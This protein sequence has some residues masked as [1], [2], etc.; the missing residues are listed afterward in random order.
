MAYYKRYRKKPI[1]K[2][3]K[4][5]KEKYLSMSLAQLEVEEKKLSE[6]SGRLVYETRSE[7]YDEANSS[8]GIDGSEYNKI[9]SRVEKSF[10]P[11]KKDFF[12]Y[13]DEFFFNNEWEKQDRER[14]RKIAKISQEIWEKSIKDENSSAY[15]NYI[16]PLQKRTK[17]KNELTKKRGRY[18]QIQLIFKAFPEIKKRVKKKEQS[19]KL[20]AFGKSSRQQG[21]SIVKKIKKNT[22]FPFRCPYCLSITEE[23]NCHVDHINPVANGG[24]SLLKNMVLV[25]KSCNIKKKDKSLRIFCKENNFNYLDICE[26]LEK[27]GKFI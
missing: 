19:A 13:L 7:L 8:E 4:E 14:K 26:E 11:L 1:N 17:L 2:I 21:E 10:P 9:R 23:E 16:A 5:I 20:A 12:D 24:L 6:E 25:C 22:E 18:N 27:L 15:K 3:P